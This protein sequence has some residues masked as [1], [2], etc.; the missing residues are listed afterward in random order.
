MVQRKGK[1]RPRKRG[2]PK[3]SDAKEVARKQ[4][5]VQDG[6]PQESGA[7]ENSIKQ[8]HDAF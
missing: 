6:C 1:K 4:D 3:N 8:C 7:N 5:S 2:R